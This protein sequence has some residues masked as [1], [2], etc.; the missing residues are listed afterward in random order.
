VSFL[1]FIKL[2]EDAG[3]E[4]LP[5]LLFIP[6]SESSLVFNFSECVVVQVCHGENG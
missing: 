4:L 6:G 5:E 1:F 2:F 3:D